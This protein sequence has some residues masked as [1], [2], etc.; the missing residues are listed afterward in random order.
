VRASA[1]DFGWEALV[2]I[3]TL[4]LATG[5]FWLAL[6]T[7]K[8]AQATAQEVQAQWRP[9]LV[10]GIRGT[11]GTPQATSPLA[12]DQENSRLYVSVR[13]AG[14]GPALFVRTLLHPEN[15]SP[16][17]WSLGAISP[18]DEVQLRISGVYSFD[19]P[20]QLLLDYRHLSGRRYASAL[21]LDVVKGQGGDMH[22]YYDVRL[23]EG[24]TV[25]PHGDAVP[26]QG[27]KLLPGAST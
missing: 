18:G 26:Q 8:L 2:A 25:T 24:A 27:L 17:H 14:R 1:W 9:A 6:T 22:R 10:P 13:N 19:A 21:V 4:C 20:K 7:S 11:P 12:Y 15:N 16:D 23:F 5:T 3:G